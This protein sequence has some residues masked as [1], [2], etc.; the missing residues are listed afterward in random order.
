MFMS[1]GDLGPNEL[2]RGKRIANQLWCTKDNARQDVVELRLWLAKTL[3]P[4]NHFIQT[5]ARQGTSKHNPLFGNTKL[6]SQDYL[7][8]SKLEYQT[9]RKKS[10]TP[11]RGYRFK[12]RLEGTFLGS[13]LTQG[14]L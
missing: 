3:G 1:Q 2:C 12:V 9:L 7:K 10:S 14:G 5:M 13:S 11:C 6:L 4:M 8:R